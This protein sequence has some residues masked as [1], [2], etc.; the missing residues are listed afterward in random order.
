[1]LDLELSGAARPADRGPSRAQQRPFSVGLPSG[2]RLRH[3]ERLISARSSAREVERGRVRTSA[4][5]LR[6]GRDQ[7]LEESLHPMPTIEAADTSANG[8]SVTSA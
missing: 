1:M 7:F 5:E 2:L 4:T 8:R 3:K 6:S